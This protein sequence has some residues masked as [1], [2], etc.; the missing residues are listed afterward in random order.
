MG[1]SVIEQRDQAAKLR[2][3][4]SHFNNASSANSSKNEKAKKVWKIV[5]LIFKTII[6]LFFL[7]IGLYGCF[8]NLTDHWTVNSTTVGNGLEM[9]FQVDPLKGVNDIRY[10]L[11]YAGSGPWYPMD[12]HSF[13]FG[14]FYALFVW[15]IAQILLHFMYATRDWPVGLNAILGLIII[16]FIIRIITLAITAR[17]TLQT[18]R[19]SEIQGKIAEINAKYKDAKD[20]QSRQKKQ[21]ET[22]ELYKKHNI[23]PL[24]PFES[25][26]IT[27]PIFLII[28]R[29]VTILRPLKFISL[30]GIW[31][32]T[33]SPISELFSNFSTT[34]WP[35]LFF[36][37]IIIPVQI[38]SQKIPQWLAKKRNKSATTVGANNQKQLKR[39]RMMQ[40]IIAIVLAVTV[41]ISAAGI[42]LY[43]FFNALFTILQSVIIHKIIMKR[44][45]N[46]STRINSKLAKLGIE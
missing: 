30:F 11:V 21:M 17:A 43:W 41:A 19:I 6:Y 27:L 13:A 44:R 14:P 18:E 35:Y 40:N 25:M 9:G 7:G 5:R 28:Y 33:T 3:T 2:F 8:Q 1:S 20:V 12:K 36:L 26:I 32:L 24:A 22:R 42:G 38:L 34:G 31:D 10:D 29:V 16:L 37:L 23:K 39:S 45:A 15:P 46:S 4:V